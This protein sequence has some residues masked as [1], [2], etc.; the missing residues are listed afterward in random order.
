M[1][2]NLC[3]ICETM[4]KRVQRKKQIKAETTVLFADLRGF[5]GAAQASD[6]GEVTDMLNVFYDQ[7]ASAIWE[8]DGIVNKFIGDAVLAVR[9]QYCFTR[10][11]RRQH[12]R[13][14]DH[15]TGLSTCIR[16]VSCFALANIP[17]ERNRAGYYSTSHLN[18]VRLVL[19]AVCD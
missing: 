11:E 7:C 1:N 6:T 18:A 2:P 5:T 14:H 4:F 15:R 10:A 9:S 3:T 17:D 16:D 12:W 19:F 13:D 8:R